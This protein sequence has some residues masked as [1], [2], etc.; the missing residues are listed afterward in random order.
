MTSQTP[1]PTAGR[2][3]P[4]AGPDQGPRVTRDEVRDLGRLRRSSTDR[5]IAGVAGG[6][7]RHL[8]IDPLVVRVVLVVLAFFGGAGLLVYGAAWLLVPD[9]RTGEAVVS[10]DERS[11]NVALVVVGALALLALLGD[12]TGVFWFPWPVVVVAAAV[13]WFMTRNDRPAGS[14]PTDGSPATSGPTAPPAGHPIDEP[15]DQ[16]SVYGAGYEAGYVAGYGGGQAGQPAPYVPPA[17]PRDPR[18]RGP[19]LFWITL[20]L[21]AIAVGLLASADIAGIDVAASA[22]PALALAVIATMLL[23]GAFFGRAGGLI[24]L[25][26]LTLPVLGATTA[27][28]DWEGESYSYA[29]ASSVAVDDTYEFDAGDLTLDLTRV[30]DLEAL[31]GRELRVEGSVGQIV[32]V[33]P[34]DLDVVVDAEVGGPGQVTLFGDEVGGIDNKL[35]RSLDGG[36]DVPEITIDVRLGVGE[37]RAV[38][39]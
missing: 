30:R 18:R 9:E 20:A 19:V 33:L 23:V 1:D 36:P 14:A 35:V 5:R 28:D 29:P 37:I 17:P 27:A 31:D 6:I 22:Y 3:G 10:L 24:L 21:I 38:T 16:A 39:K 12:S 32:L 26:L 25:G 8:D 4:T 34:D 15:G 11:R 7:A 2:P 13:L